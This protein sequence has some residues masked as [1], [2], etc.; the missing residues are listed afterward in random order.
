MALARDSNKVPMKTEPVPG[1]D[2][3][4][5]LMVL[6]IQREDPGREFSRGVRERC[7]MRLGKPEGSWEEA[8]QFLLQGKNTY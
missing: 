7:K 2:A 8:L 5:V 4:Q 1:F 3:D 6:N